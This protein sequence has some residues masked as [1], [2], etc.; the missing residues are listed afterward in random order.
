MTEQ[1][2]LTTVCTRLRTA[3]TAVQIDE[4]TDTTYLAGYS[5]I[6]TKSAVVHLSDQLDSR[7]LFTGWIHCLKYPFT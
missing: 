4:I 1:T 2:T 5:T 6:N 3:L 7:L